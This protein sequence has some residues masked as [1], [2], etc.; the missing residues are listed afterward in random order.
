MLGRR[1][2]NCNIP[3]TKGRMSLKLEYMDRLSLGKIQITVAQQKV[4][5]L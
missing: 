1:P 3:E 4:Q 5:S 2:R